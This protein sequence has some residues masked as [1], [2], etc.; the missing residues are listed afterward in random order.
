MSRKSSTRREHFLNVD[1]IA[2]NLSDQYGDY[3]HRNKSNPLDELLFILCSL[4]TNEELYRSTY[5]SLRARFSSFQKLSD[6]SEEEIERAIARGGLARQKA[7]AIR[8]ILA[9]LKSTFGTP[10]LAPLRSMTDAECE[11]YLCR[12][13]GVGMKTAR[14][15]LM[16]SLNRSVFPV[17]SNC[18]RICRRLGWVCPTRRDKSC[19]PEDMERIQAGIPPQLRFTLHVNFVSHGRM[20]CLPSAPMCARCCIRKYCRTGR[21]SSIETT[22]TN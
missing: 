5:A 7:R 6:A 21:H 2:Q 8:Q 22:G 17:D 13:P 18:W 20:C 15:V 1:E 3:A 9:H 10:T 16:Y 14:C 11:Q 4:Q 19:S 12:L